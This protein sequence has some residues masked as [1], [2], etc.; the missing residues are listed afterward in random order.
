MKI[1]IAIL[2]STGSIGKTT[3]QIIKKKSNLFKVDTLV[4]KSNYDL[5][6]KQIRKFKPDNFIITDKKNYLRI[7]KI[8]NIKTNICYNINELNNKKNKIDITIAAILGL[9]GL[10]PTI[11]FLTRSKKILLANKESIIC[12][13]KIIK[14]IANK[15]KTK[16]IPI[17]SEH[18][19][20][21]NLAANHKNADI[22]K[23]YITASG[24]PFLKLAYNKFNTIKPDQA[25]N[26]PKWKMGKKIS[27][28]S[29]TLMNKILEL[30]EAKNIFDYD[31]SKYEIIIHPQSLVHAIVKLKNGITKFLYHEPN[32]IIPIS[33]AIFNNN[34]NI[35]SLIKFN[36][37][38]DKIKNLEFL[39][40]DKKRFPIIKILPK[41]NKYESTAIII[42]AAN[43][44]LVNHFL[45][46]KVS[47]NSIIKYI[48]QVLKD[49]NYKKYAI[50]KP[51][52][53]SKIY[54]IDKWT[55]QKV[56]FLLKQND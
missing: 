11:F 9:A 27:V 2:G 15:N 33:N 10:E 20:I 46:R 29:S 56:K 39:N 24:G 35:D 17:D 37:K 8:K 30:L 16:I 45:K 5:I 28:D 40:V 48:F 23:I 38:K 32:M 13:W 44:E 47:Y 52:T 21:N 14:K 43:E 55:R 50:Q 42:N 18:F 7:K 4:A 1:K 54:K 19:S 31:F 51:S 22:E 36:K 3:L 6:L 41:L 53:L 49:K 26:H 12:G 25:I 34:V